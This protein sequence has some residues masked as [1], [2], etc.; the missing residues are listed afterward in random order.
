[1]VR[2]CPTPMAQ[3]LLKDRLSMSFYES[4]YYA[5]NTTS[6]IDTVDEVWG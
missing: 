4:F 6:L 1:M 2:A 5:V 3:M